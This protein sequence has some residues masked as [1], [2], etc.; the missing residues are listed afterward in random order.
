[1]LDKIDRYVFLCLYQIGTYITEEVFTRQYGN[2]DDVIVHTV[3]LVWGSSMKQVNAV[4]Q[5]LRQSA[6][7]AQ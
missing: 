5:A 2:D 6:R 7:S 3:R 1:M 4:R